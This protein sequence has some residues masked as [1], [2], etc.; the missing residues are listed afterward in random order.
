MKQISTYLNF[1]KEKGRPLSDINPGSN[2]FALTVDEALHALKL[3]AKSQIAVLGGD[4][5]SP[6][7][8]GKLIYAYQLW[9]N[10]EEY[11]FLN[12]C[13]NKKENEDFDD[14]VKRSHLIA[15]ESIKMADD[16]AKH[17]GKKCYIVI[18]I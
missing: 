1:I 9:G 13:C 12:W 11:H 10:G 18:V 3:L 6:K 5:L 16:I 4:I 17:L 15:K 2:E 14:Y 7:E 8:H